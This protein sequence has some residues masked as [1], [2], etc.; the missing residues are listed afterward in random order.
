MLAAALPW[1]Q[2]ELP[3]EAACCIEP[4]WAEKVARCSPRQ[5]AV[6]LIEKA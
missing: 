5:E 6:Q 4:L 2:A 3:S 1:V